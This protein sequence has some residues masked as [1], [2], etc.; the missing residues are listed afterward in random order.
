MVP[1]S[2]PLNPHNMDGHPKKDH[3]RW[4]FPVAL[5]LG[6][7]ILDSLPRQPVVLDMAAPSAWVPGD[8]TEGRHPHP[9][10]PSVGAESGGE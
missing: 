9:R 10:G 3:S 6:T 2:S 4:N 8:R 1:S 7:Q 5:P